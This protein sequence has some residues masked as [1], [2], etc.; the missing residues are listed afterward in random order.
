[1]A[2]PTWTAGLTTTDPY[3]ARV[4]SG[5]IGGFD[6]VYG[7]G[8]FNSTDV[9]TTVPCRSGS[10]KFKLILAQYWPA[11]ENLRIT[12]NGDGTVTFTRTDTTSGAKF[13]FIALY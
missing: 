4:Q 1:M 8:A 11:N 13:S 2:A 7:I 12:D 9:T 6:L 5:N 10:I 3:M